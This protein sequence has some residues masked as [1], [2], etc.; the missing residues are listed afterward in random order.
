[1]FSILGLVIIEG[2]EGT[3]SFLL[4]MANIDFG[5]TCSRSQPCEGR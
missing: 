2:K 3:I 5:T 1:M 4:L